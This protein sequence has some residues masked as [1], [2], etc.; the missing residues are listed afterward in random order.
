MPAC[1]PTPSTTTCTPPPPPT[2]ARYEAAAQGRFK[3]LVEADPALAPHF[4]VPGVIPGLSSDAVITTE[5]VNGVTIDKVG[6]SSSNIWKRSATQPQ[7]AAL[8]TPVTI[9]CFSVPMQPSWAAV[10]MHHNMLAPCSLAGWALP[11]S[12]H[13]NPLPPPS[14]L[15]PG[16]WVGPGGA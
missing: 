5:W 7:A 8:T 6:A 3:A 14:L 16:G 2:P 12:N 4:H 11:M 15:P 10:C 9:C 1:V 13:P